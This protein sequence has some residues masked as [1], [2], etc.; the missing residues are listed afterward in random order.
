YGKTRPTKETKEFNSNIR[1][2]EYFFDSTKII[3]FINA[4]I[5][6]ILQ[7]LINIHILIDN[8]NNHLTLLSPTFTI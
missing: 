7:K 5:H 3:F 1:Y 4:F 8:A 2:F 6:H